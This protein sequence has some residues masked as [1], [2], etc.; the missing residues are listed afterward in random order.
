MNTFTFLH[1]ILLISSQIEAVICLSKD[2]F[3]LQW[4]THT[5][6]SVEEICSI[7][8]TIFAVGQDYILIPKTDYSCLSVLTKHG[9]MV[10]FAISEKVLLLILFIGNPHARTVQSIIHKALT[11]KSNIPELSEDIN[12]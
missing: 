10:T 4:R 6:V 5:T 3:P 7:A 1:N 8:A 9:Y 12:I 2:G 11:E